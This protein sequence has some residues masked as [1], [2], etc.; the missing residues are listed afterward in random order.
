VSHST[1]TNDRHEA[2]RQ[3]P[4]DILADRAVQLP[5]DGIA[6]GKELA[7]VVVGKHLDPIRRVH[8]LVVAFAERND[9]RTVRV[10]SLRKA[11]SHERKALE[12]ILGD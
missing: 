1:A 9:G 5:V 2:R 7:A 8:A 11:L 4:P 3:V 12:K 10:I 6:T